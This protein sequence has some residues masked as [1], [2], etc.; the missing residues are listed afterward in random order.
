MENFFDGM[1]STFHN[2]RHS[3]ATSPE[4]Q[5]QVGEV[6]YRTAQVLAGDLRGHLIDK[7]R[8][9]LGSKLLWYAVFQRI[10]EFT[11]ATVTKAVLSA[12][13]LRELLRSV[14]EA[15]SDMKLIAGWFRLLLQTLD[16]DVQVDGE[17]L[18]KKQSTTALR[19]LDLNGAAGA[20]VRGK[21]FRDAQATDG[22]P[23]DLD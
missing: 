14:S 17:P 9:G 8:K 3:S 5:G 7:T 18:L 23:Y 4:G 22:D 6:A 16:A 13:D 21:A 12:R 15:W 20:G 1:I 11:T 10:R 19:D 2:A